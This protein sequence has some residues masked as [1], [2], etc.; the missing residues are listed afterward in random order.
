M[1]HTGFVVSYHGTTNVRADE[2]ER[3]EFRM[4]RRPGLWLGYGRYFFQDGPIHAIRWGQYMAR[5]ETGDVAN[6]VVLSAEIDLQECIDLTDRRYWSAIRSLW[7]NEV[8]D[9]GLSQLGINVLLDRLSMTDGERAELSEEDKSALGRNYVDCEVMNSFIQ[10]MKD[11]MRSRGFDYTTVR[12]AFI[13]G[14]PVY[15][16]SWLWNRSSV[17]VSVL[18]PRAMGPIKRVTPAE[19]AEFLELMDESEFDPGFGAG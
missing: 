6:A 17:V 11:K 3:T 7:R 13:E 14:R 16:D 19:L 4:S 18:E 9:S 1:S 8:K 15:D 2:I 10:R 5:K 12:A